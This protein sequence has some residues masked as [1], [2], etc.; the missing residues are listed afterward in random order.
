MAEQRSR[1]DASFSRVLFENVSGEWVP[2]LEL[3]FNLFLPQVQSLVTI[4][5]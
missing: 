3:D 4:A 1:E 5:K 2:G